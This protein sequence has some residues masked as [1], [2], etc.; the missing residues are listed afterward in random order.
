MAA[1][2]RRMGGVQGV[3][4]T[5][6]QIEEAKQDADDIGEVMAAARQRIVGDLM[7]DEELL[8]ELEELDQDDLDASLTQVASSSGGAADA[9]GSERYMQ[10]PEPAR[11]P[12]RKQATM[13]EELAQLELSMEMAPAM[14]AGTP[15]MVSCA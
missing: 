3:E 8:A 15:M 1:E 12:V 5:L 2:T 6:D 11:A 13:E 4:E 7:E 14:A 9:A 10:L